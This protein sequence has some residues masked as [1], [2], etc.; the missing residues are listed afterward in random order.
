MIAAHAGASSVQL[1]A[2]FLLLCSFPSP[3][4]HL[5]HH[6]APWSVFILSAVY[7]FGTS[8]L[9]YDLI[10]LMTSIHLLY[11]SSSCFVSQVHVCEPSQFFA[12]IG[13]LGHKNVRNCQLQ[14]NS[15]PTWKKKRQ[16]R[17]KVT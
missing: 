8:N 16:E 12:C 14:G 1:Y 2:H 4:F 17:F 6:D 10:S 3:V 13:V 9:L 5:H 7:A 15:A 11:K